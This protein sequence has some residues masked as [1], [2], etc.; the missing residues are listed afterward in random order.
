MNKLIATR[1]VVIA[2]VLALAFLLAA[3]TGCSHEHDYGADGLCKI[4][5][6]KCSHTYGEDGLCTVCSKECEH[7]YYRKICTVCGAEKPPHYDY[8]AHI[9]E[10][11]PVI[12][13]VTDDGDSSWAEGYTNF[14]PSDPASKDRPYYGCTVSV[15]NCGTEYELSAKASVKVRGNYTSTYPKKPFRIKF[16]KKQGM[17]GL[18][19]GAKCKNWVLLADFKDCSLQRNSMAFYLGQQILGSDDYYCSDFRQVEGRLNGKYWGVYLLAEQQQVNENR[20]DISEPEEGELNTDIGYLVEYDGYYN[21]EAPTERFEC[22]YM[23]NAPLR[24]Y[25]GSTVFPS[26]HGFAIKNDVYADD[27]GISMQQQ[28]IK[29]YIDY[30]YEICYK[31]VYIRKYYTFN[32]YFTQLVPYSTTTENPV[33]ETVERIVDIRSLVDVYILNEIA[34][35]ADVAWSSFYMDV[36]FGADGEKLLRF[37]APWDF[38]SAFGLKDSCAS[39]TGLFAANSANPWL[40]LFINE[41]WFQNEIKAKWREL[42]EAD[43]QSGAVA[44]VKSL[45]YNNKAAYERNFGKWGF[46]VS[47]ESNQEAAKVKNHSEASAQFLNWLKKRFSYLNSVWL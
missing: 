16:D 42:Y 38:D 9:S 41:D 20:V 4:C 29:N 44:L 15:G 5:K 13:I 12:D 3:A 34:C 28:F 1:K 39:G 47:G 46:I 33:R 32:E 22:T 27:D 6:I 18:N 14:D 45:N 31:A 37:E 7:E 43:V 23:N 10:T 40:I 2:L 35:D 30:V 25:D 11:L 36:D 26:L 17:L 8:K 24:T 19:G 21:L